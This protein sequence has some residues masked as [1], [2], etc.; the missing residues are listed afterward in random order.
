MVGTAENV[1]QNFQEKE[2]GRYLE[3]RPKIAPQYCS[4]CTKKVKF[5]PVLE[6]ALVTSNTK[7]IPMMHNYERTKTSLL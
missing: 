4:Y 1:S 7:Q 2:K 3:G 6:V 5:S